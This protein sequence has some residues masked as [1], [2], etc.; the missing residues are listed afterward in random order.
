[1]RW[2]IILLL[3]V[4]PASAS[5]GPQPVTTQGRFGPNGVGNYGPQPTGTPCTTTDI[6]GITLSPSSFNGGSPTGT[7]VGSIG[8]SATGCLFTGSLSLAGTDAASFQIVG[9]NLETNGVVAAGTYHINLT[10]TQAG[11]TGS[12]FTQTN[13]PV[14][15][16]AQTIA[17]VGLSPTTFVGG[18]PTGTVV[19]AITVGMSF[20]SFTGTLS[21]TGTNA[22]SFQLSSTSLPANLE[23]NGTV[24]AGTYSLNI[25]ATQS[26]AAGSP[27][28]QPETVT[29]TTPAT[30][31][32]VT[33]SPGTFTGGAPD[34]TVV[35]TISVTVSSGSFGGSLS[36]PGG[37]DAARFKIVGSN[38]ELN[39][40][41]AA[42]SYS[43]TITATDATFSNS[44]FT[45][46]PISITG[47]GG[48]GCTNSLNFSQACNSQY[49]GAL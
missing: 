13:I 30:I 21:L 37:T 3:L 5:Y 31:S 14:I 6:V 11:A 46:S 26:G 16:T 45:S 17:S 27:F 22:S 29:G 39:G 9:S 43:I 12:P 40:S 48:G 8:V 19:G 28:T 15:G 38:L 4:V 10:A 44:P 35:G 23:T 49:L 20:G 42:G 2:L 32:S 36:G 1:M 7:V 47:S 33:V 24:A 25:V 34:G 18:S 41:Q